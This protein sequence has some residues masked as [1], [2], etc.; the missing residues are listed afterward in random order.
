MHSITIKF[1][2]VHPEEV[3]WPYRQICV[4]LAWE[5]TL[6]DQFDNQQIFAESSG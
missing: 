1:P 4:C 5:P 6:V 3:Q 2:E